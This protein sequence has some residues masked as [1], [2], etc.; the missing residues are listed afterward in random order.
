MAH[1]RL[2]ACCS[3]DARAVLGRGFA[4]PV[5]GTMLV[6]VCPL[7]CVALASLRGQIRGRHKA[8]RPHRQPEAKV[9]LHCV[10]TAL[11]SCVTSLWRP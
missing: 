11:L 6:G 4:Q 2:P 1:G 3:G 8:I 7:W 9:W 5:L 10:I